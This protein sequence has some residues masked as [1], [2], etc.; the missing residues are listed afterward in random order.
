MRSELELSRRQ[1]KAALKNDEASAKVARLIYTNDTAP[2]IKRV[3]NGNGF[4]YYF[5]NKEIKDTE[6]LL[7]IKSLAIPPAWDDVWISSFPEGHLQV[8]GLD[9]AKRKQYRYHPQWNEIRSQTKF[10]R[11]LDFGL[12]LPAIRRK[13]DNDLK[14]PGLSRE[15]VLALVVTIL[16]TAYIRIGNAAYEKLNGSY[17]LT[18]LKNKHVK[19]DGNTAKFC[20]IGKKGIR[21]NITLKS[22]RLSNIIKKCKEIPGKQLFEYIDNDGNI[23]GID[24][25]MVNEY[26][27]VISGNDFTA[28]D[29]RT[30][31]GTV[32]AL[33]ALNEIGAWTNQT[34]LKRKINLMYDFVALDLGNTRN[35]CRKHYVHPIIVKK[36]EENNLPQ[37]FNIQ[38]KNEDETLLKKE[39][40]SLLTILEK[41]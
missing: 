27:K 3:R 15:K 11:L 7:R 32:S 33:R 29:F 40:L 28:K 20:F 17:G 25:G 4:K 36:Y 10:F 34:D 8:T 31:A 21:T 2:G 22:R 26:I 1:I 16:D 12:S 6:E 23:N 37:Y 14:K 9:T 24:S 39:E 18:T 5:N 13:I 35:V 30:W 41:I 19:I 38:P